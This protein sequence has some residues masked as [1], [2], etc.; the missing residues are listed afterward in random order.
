MRILW[1]FKDDEANTPVQ[2]VLMMN[3]GGGTAGERIAG[4][5]GTHMGPDVEL[6]YRAGDPQ[7]SVIPWVEYRNTSTGTTATYTAS[8]SKD[9]GGKTFLMQC[10]DCHNRQ[11]HSFEQP[12]EAVDGAMTA[13]R[14]PAD[15]P[16]AH[17]SGVELLKATYTDSDDAARK[18]PPAFAA[19]YQQKYPDVA[20]RRRA[21][22][23]RAGKALLELYQRNVFPEFGVKWGSYPNNLGHADN[24]GCFR[25]HDESHTSAQTKKTITQ[26]CN[27]CH[28]ALAVEETSPEILKTLGVLPGV[29]KP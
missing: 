3:V 4:I 15:L 28:Q 16:F 21:D 9:P 10:A 17:K 24:A 1:K 12:D 13:G 5:H 25:C 11:G 7:R 22:I 14:I 6:R 2:T 29:Q 8:G 20:S 19:L 27:A 18:I 26:D 23:D